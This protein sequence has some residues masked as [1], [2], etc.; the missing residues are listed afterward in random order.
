MSSIGILDDC[1]FYESTEERFLTVAPRLRAIKL[2]TNGSR[3]NDTKNVFTVPKFR[4]QMKCENETTKQQHEMCE[5]FHA[6]VFQ[7]RVCWC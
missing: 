4:L 6:Y 7:C 2:I 3:G 5:G 1:E